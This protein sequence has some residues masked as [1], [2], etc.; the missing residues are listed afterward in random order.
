MTE[1][2][3]LMQLKIITELL[4]LPDFQV[5]RVL[6]QTGTS[7]IFMELAKKFHRKRHIILNYFQQRLT[8]AIS[9]GINNKTERLK[10]MAYGYQGCFILPTENSPAPDPPSNETVADADS[11]P[12]RPS[13]RRVC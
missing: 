10:R 6:E 3:N 13:R 7:I 1:G 12:A 5:V 2:R 9:E 11:E 4:N 8:S